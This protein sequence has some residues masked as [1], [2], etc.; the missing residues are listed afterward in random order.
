ML[1]RY[2]NRVASNIDVRYAHSRISK[3]S[4]RLRITAAGEPEL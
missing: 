2:L 4:D 3:N 1:R